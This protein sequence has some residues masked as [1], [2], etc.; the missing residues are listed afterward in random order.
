MAAAV[1]GAVSLSRLLSIL[2][3]LLLLSAPHG[4]SGLH[5]K[6]ALPLDTVTF[7]KGKDNA[8][9]D[10]IHESQVEDRRAGRGRRSSAP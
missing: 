5:T 4:G 3:G 7:Y 2:L 10:P 6:G 9:K 1:P 8:G